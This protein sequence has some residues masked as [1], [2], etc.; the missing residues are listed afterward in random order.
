MFNS[1]AECWNHTFY[2]S[3]MRPLGGGVPQGRVLD[4]I[5]KSFGSYFK[6]REQFETTSN[7][8]FG[9]GYVWLVWT[10]DG[11]KVTPTANADNPLTKEGQVPLLAIVSAH[12]YNL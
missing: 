10:A 4:L 11:R 6:F 2:F 9:S 1:A 7:G 5:C 12:P 3:G 8:V